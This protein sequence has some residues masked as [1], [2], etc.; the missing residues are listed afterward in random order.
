MIPLCGG[1]LIG[2]CADNSLTQLFGGRNTIRIIWTKRIEKHGKTELLQ[3]L[4]PFWKICD[5]IIMLLSPRR[6]PWRST[7]T[8]SAAQAACSRTRKARKPRK[9]KNPGRH[10]KH[11][12]LSGYPRNQ[13]LPLS[14][15]TVCLRPFFTNCRTPDFCAGNRE[16]YFT[17]PRLYGIV[18]CVCVLRTRPPA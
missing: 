13:L 7:A 1:I 2:S 11:D 5:G 17:K 18:I 14:R 3:N 4:H 10:R 6:R 9:Q 15:G 12:N 16:N 8:A